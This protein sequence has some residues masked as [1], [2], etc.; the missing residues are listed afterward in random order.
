MPEKDL[1]ERVR[2]A[3]KDLGLTQQQFAERAGVKHRAYQ[4]FENRVSR[5]PQ[6]DNLRKILRAAGIDPEDAKAERPRQV[7]ADVAFFLET[8]ELWL[9]NMEPSLRHLVIRDLTRRIV[10]GDFTKLGIVGNF[11]SHG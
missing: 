9:T 4:N 3:R 10:S 1:P 2:D 6:P 8:V 7:D 5:R 11:V